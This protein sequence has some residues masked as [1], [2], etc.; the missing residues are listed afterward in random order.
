MSKS[1]NQMQQTAETSTEKVSWALLSSWPPAL[2]K[3]G[4]E[5]LGHPCPQGYLEMQLAEPRT[6]AAE[7]R[8]DDRGHCLTP[9]LIFMPRR[10]YY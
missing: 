1:A 9:P 3:A 6:E 10:Y 8:E 7:P 5:L 4:L 2:P